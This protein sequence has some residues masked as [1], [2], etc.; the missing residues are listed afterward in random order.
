MSINQASSINP[1]APVVILGGGL[2][3]LSCAYHL[4]RPLQLFEREREVGGTARSYTVDGFTFDFTGHLLH[5]HTDYTKKLIRRLLRGN[6]FECQRR[7]WIYSKGV[8]TRYPFQANLY[9]LPAQVIEDCYVGLRRSKRTYGPDPLGQ[10]EGPPL[11]F[12]EWCQ[13][14]FGGGI[15]R[16]FMIPYNQKLWTVR[17]EEMTPDWCGQFV[18]QPKLEDVLVGSLT[19]QQKAFGYNARFIYPKR[20]GIQRLAQGM[21]HGLSNVN[22]GVSFEKI[23]W[24]EQKVRLD[25][26]KTVDYSHIVSTIPLPELLKRLEPFPSEIIQ[27]FQRLRWTSIHNINIGV[28]RARISDKSWIYF[29]EKSF[30]FYRVGF[31]MNFTPHVVPKG[32][33]SMYVEVSHRPDARPLDAAGKKSLWRKVRQGLIQCGVLKAS[34]TFAVVSFLPIRYAYVLYDRHRTEAL[35]VLFPW[36]QNVARISSIGRYGGWKYSFMEEAILEGKKAAEELN[37]K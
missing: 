24:E 26:G 1:Q 4:R 28:R 7:T 25:T 3:G 17:P 13:R 18:P 32:C 33:S 34:D 10:K 36:L 16:H 22:L 5:L 31:P 35:S 27:P 6:I 19:D 23:F 8:Y 29:P 11:T 9:G 20:G 21:A 14:L 37:G 30:V 2:A 12:G 15:S